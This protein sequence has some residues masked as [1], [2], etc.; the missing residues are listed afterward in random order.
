MA[1][2]RP[3]TNN[4]TLSQDMVFV[5]DKV[6]LPE[7]FSRVLQFSPHCYSNA[8][9][10]FI[11]CRHYITLALFNKSPLFYS[12]SP[13]G[14]KNKIKYEYTY[15]G[16]P[17]SKCTDFYFKCLLD[18]SE[19]TSYFLQSVTLGKLHSGSNIF[20]TDHSSTGSHFP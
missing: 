4:L 5:V 10:T 9:L 15:V 18:S 3:Q 17:K 2:N 16:C 12:P 1:H 7:V 8:P 14:T 11:Y 20:S 13:P 6:A 19:I